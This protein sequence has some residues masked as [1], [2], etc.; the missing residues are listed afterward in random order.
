MSILSGQARSW[1]LEQFAKNAEE[2]RRLGADLYDRV[3]K[4]VE[5]FSGVGRAL[6]QAVASY[7]K[8]VGSL[9][10]RVLVSARKFRELGATAQAEIAEVEP[11]ERMTRNVQTDLLVPTA[12]DFEES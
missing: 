4:F 8:A 2:I 5:N 1:R 11:V 6:D 7:D 10:R 12:N 9:E 3:A